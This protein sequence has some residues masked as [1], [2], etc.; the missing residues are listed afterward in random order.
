[1]LKWKEWQL[2]FRPQS[3]ISE[4][5][6]I[7]VTMITTQSQ[8]S[9]KLVHSLVSQSNSMEIP[10]PLPT[11]ACGRVYIHSPTEMQLSQQEY[12]TAQSCFHLLR[13]KTWAAFYE[14]DKTP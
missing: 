6:P 5:G 2:G 4:G 7:T 11:R 10:Y 9:Q 14:N 12:L 13:W 8:V 3:D 1:M